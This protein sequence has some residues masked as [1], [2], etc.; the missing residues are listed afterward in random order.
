MLVVADSSPLIALLQIE[1]LDVLP[2]LFGQVLIPPIVAAELTGTKRPEIVKRF[3]VEPPSW[4]LVRQ[5]TAV[6]PIPKLDPGETE[7]ISLALE[8]KADLLLVD[9]RQAHRYAISRSIRT[10][11]TVG[12]LEVAASEKLLDLNKA[13]DRLKKIDFWID[14]AF[15]DERLRFYHARTGR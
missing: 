4:L 2:K 8:L 1:H 14:E 5:P 9:E 15:L 13:F 10:T 6:E 7:A 11:G 3:F 12:I